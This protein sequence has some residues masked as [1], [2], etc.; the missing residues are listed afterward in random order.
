MD[1]LTCAEHK[2][3]T[4]VLK[5]TYPRGEEVWEEIQRRCKADLIV[6]VEILEPSWHD[7]A[8]VSF[9]A[10][11]ANESYADLFDLKYEVSGKALTVS[12]VSRGEG[13][14]ADPSYPEEMEDV[15]FNE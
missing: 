11:K 3:K 12:F 5:H 8:M 13:A 6:T 7:A 1:E 2:M 9:R 14:P 15:L 4:W 10:A